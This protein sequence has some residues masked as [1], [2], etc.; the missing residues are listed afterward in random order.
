MNLL[1]R[2]FLNIEDIEIEICKNVNGIYFV[3]HH[4]YW[5]ITYGKKNPDPIYNCIIYNLELMVNNRLSTI[6]WS[7]YQFKLEKI[8]F[9]D[10]MEV[11]TALIPMQMFEDFIHYQANNY[12]GN[13]PDNECTRLANWLKNN[14]FKELAITHL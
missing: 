14:S 4:T 10:G 13:P 9:E 5:S 2:C 8:C 7:G 1:K 3:R 11:E 12:R 6:K